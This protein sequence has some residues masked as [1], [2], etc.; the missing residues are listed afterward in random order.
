MK[1][2][3]MAIGIASTAFICG[4][5]NMD[6]LDYHWSFQ[7]AYIKVGGEWRTVKVKAW[8][9]YEYSDMIAVE[10]D[11]QVFVTH[12]ANVVLVKDK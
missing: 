8:H 11:T 6:I 2:I 5:G 12:S 9:D 7:R 4:C 3:I 10:T 1:K